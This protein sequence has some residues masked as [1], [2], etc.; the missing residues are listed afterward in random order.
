MKK[1]EEQINIICK[2]EQSLWFAMRATY[3]RELDAQNYLANH[4]I[5][6]FIPM[7]YKEFI[8]SKQKKRELVPIIRSLIFVHTTPEK[9]QAIKQHIPYLQ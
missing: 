8:K 1:D 5:E 7:H 6:S 3:R 9:I 4:G 2:Q